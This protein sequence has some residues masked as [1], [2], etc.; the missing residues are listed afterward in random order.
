MKEWI[1]ENTS[2]KEEQ[3]DSIINLNTVIING[4]TNNLPNE[5][6]IDH[7]IINICMFSYEY[8]TLFRRM[9]YKVKRIKDI[10][11]KHYYVYKNIK[12]YILGEF[13]PIIADEVFSSRRLKQ[14]F[15]INSKICL[16][17]KINTFLITALCTHPFKIPKK[18]YIHTFVLL[19]TEDGKKYILDG[20]S[21]T[22][23]DKDTYFSIFNPKIISCIPKEKLKAD[24]EL[25]KPYEKDKS[26]YRPEYLCFPKET[27]KAVKKLQRKK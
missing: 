12:F 11:K 20:T 15:Y 24:L 16:L 21:N 8:P 2:I 18:K 22:I 25:L 10:N 13:F 7:P 6:I 19:K 17:P 23:M 4:K 3:Y 14:C 26:I 9:K 5:K 1:L 27:L